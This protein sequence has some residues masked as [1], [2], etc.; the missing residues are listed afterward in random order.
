[1]IL[2]NESNRFFF[3]LLINAISKTWKFRPIC[4]HLELLVFDKEIKFV[5]EWSDTDRDWLTDLTMWSVRLMLIGWDTSRFESTRY[6]RYLLF[7]MFFCVHPILLR[8]EEIEFSLSIFVLYKIKS[9]LTELIGR[10][11]P[12]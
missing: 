2:H 4:L 3:N 11:L 7:I 12:I 6:N 8:S 5:K 10:K 9:S 1:M